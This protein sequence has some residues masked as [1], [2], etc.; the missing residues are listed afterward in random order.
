MD[1]LY[2][3]LTKEQK[4][5][6]G[7]LATNKIKK[8]IEASD[9]TEAIDSEMKET[10][11]WLLSEGLSADDVLDGVREKLNKYISDKIATALDL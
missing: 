5:E 3:L 6:V 7:Q 4:L 10:I 8:A 2:N 11:T 9:I 1:E